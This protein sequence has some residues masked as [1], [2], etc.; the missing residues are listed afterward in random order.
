MRLSSA[1]TVDPLLPWT[2][3]QTGSYGLYRLHGSYDPCQGQA[4]RVTA[5][6]LEVF[7][8][9]L[10]HL[11]ESSR[12]FLPLQMGVCGLWIFSH[13]EQ[14][15]PPTLL[16]QVTPTR[17]AKVPC[18][19]WDYRLHYPEPGPLAADPRVVLTYWA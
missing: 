4:N 6:D 12:E 3:G 19:L 2:D 10:I 15:T 16:S 7:W 5:V 17:L 13:D 11:F 9:T 14:G 8:K 18:S 1:R